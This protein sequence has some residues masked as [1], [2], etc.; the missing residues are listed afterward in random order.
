MRSITKDVCVIETDKFY[1][2]EV[3]AKEYYVTD[4]NG[5]EIFKGNLE[6]CRKFIFNSWRSK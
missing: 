6:D 5:V 3:S 2:W 1:C 4:L